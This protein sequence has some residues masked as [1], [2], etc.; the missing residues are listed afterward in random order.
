MRPEVANA[1]LRV[2]GASALVKTRLRVAAP[3]ATAGATYGRKRGPYRCDVLRRSDGSVR[4]AFRSRANVAPSTPCVRRV[5]GSRVLTACRAPKHAPDDT[6]G[7][8]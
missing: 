6:L 5:A 8:T 4:Q 3:P 1:S 2:P 7:D